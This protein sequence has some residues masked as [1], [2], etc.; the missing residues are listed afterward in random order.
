[1]NELPS[2]AELVQL[3]GALLNREHLRTLGLHDRDVDRLMRSAE[4]VVFPG[5]R[6]VFVAAEYARAWLE[7]K[8]TR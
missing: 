3:P 6:R 1:V 7:E 4:V 5:S 8:A 2:A